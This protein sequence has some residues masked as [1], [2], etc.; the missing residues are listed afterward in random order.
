MRPLGSATRSLQYFYILIACIIFVL[1]GERPKLYRLCLE[2]VR[3]D[4]IMYIYIYNYVCV[5]L[6]SIDEFVVF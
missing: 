6:S 2:C 3:I 5:S 4:S 1:I